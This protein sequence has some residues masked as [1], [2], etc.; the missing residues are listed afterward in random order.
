MSLE[1]DDHDLIEVTWA[2][3]DLWVRQG[4]GAFGQAFGQVGFSDSI[5]I[6]PLLYVIFDYAVG[7]RLGQG[8]KHLSAKP[9]EHYTEQKTGR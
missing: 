6:C 7:G 8:I 5:F 4:L 1:N 9:N 3:A 2:G